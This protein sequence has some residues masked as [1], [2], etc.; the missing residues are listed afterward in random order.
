MKCL[1]LCLAILGQWGNA[2]TEECAWNPDFVDSTGGW[3][4]AEGPTLPTLRDSRC[5]EYNDLSVIWHYNCT[6]GTTINVR[7]VG[8]WKCDGF[9]STDCDEYV[10]GYHLTGVAAPSLV[11]F[12]EQLH[13]TSAGNQ[14]APMLWYEVD[15]DVPCGNVFMLEFRAECECWRNVQIGDEVTQVDTGDVRIWINRTTYEM[16]TFPIIETIVTPIMEL[17]RHC[18]VLIDNILAYSAWANQE[19]PSPP[20]EMPADITI[21]R[22]PQ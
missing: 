19:C 22:E 3:I 8:D 10:Y 9:D 7:I 13:T 2:Q 16:E 18:L 5:F 17:Q 1:L 6:P 14:G 21:E 12:G 11:H 20:A 4:G 15:V